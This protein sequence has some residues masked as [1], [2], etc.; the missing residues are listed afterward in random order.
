MGAILLLMM[1][2]SGTRMGADVPKQYLEVEGRPVFWHILRAYAAMEELTGICVVSHR[3][4]LDYVRGQMADVSFRCPVVLTEGGDTR[5]ASVRC[6]LRAAA[7]MAAP[8][9]VVLI[10]DATHPYVDR[11]GT[12]RVIGAVRETGG[13][14]LGAMQYDTCYEMDENGRIVRVVPWQ[15][16]TAGASPEAFRY[17]EIS[18]IYFDSSE[19]ELARMTSAGAIA[20][21]HGIPMQVIPAGVL[22][23]KLTYP[24]DL[25]LFRLLAA[26][27]FFPGE[28]PREKETNAK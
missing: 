12:R 15:T 14:T 23:L 6:G 18:R 1:G 21:A 3:D 9:D 22:N 20:L 25:K 17:G 13:A 11:E 19:E 16:L 5:S 27:Y 8:E 26:S 2:G 4:W 24:E 7:S 10:H 28:T